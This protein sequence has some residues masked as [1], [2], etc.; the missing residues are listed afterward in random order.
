M[1]EDL[2]RGM[3]VDAEEAAGSLTHVGKTYFK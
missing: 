2:V 1:A 3:Q